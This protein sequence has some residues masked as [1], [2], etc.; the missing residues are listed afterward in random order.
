[1][2]YKSGTI[3][4]YDTSCSKIRDAKNFMVSNY[5]S[6]DENGELQV[7]KSVEFMIV[8]NNRQ[9]KMFIPYDEFVG[10]NP[11]VVLS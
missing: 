3:K 11:D 6:Y 2:V 4:I 10:A 8:G 1:M 9:W 5:E 7:K